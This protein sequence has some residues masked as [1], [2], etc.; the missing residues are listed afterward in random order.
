MIV[1]F[2]DFGIAG[3][4]VGQM[5]AVLAAKAPQEP[6]IDLFHEA[7][8]HDPMAA[9]YLLPA[10]ISEFPAGST[11]LAVVDPGVGGDR[12]PLIVQAGGSW[13]VGPDN[14]L[15]EL[16]IR[17]QSGAQAWEIT[18]RPE[19]LS[20]SFHGRDLFAPVA[21]MLATG[22]APPG[23]E[24]ALET[25]RRTDWP[26]ELDQ[27]IYIDHFGNAMTGRRVETV[28]DG[29]V[30]E[31]AAHCCP[32]ARTFSDQAPGQPFWYEN[33]N[34]LAEIAVNLGRAERLP[35][36]VGEAIHWLTSE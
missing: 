16:I 28:P 34:G 8:P 27:I 10:L 6:I 1:L 11:F 26:D 13:F 30:L 3:P 17:R 4:Y 29:S 12:R 2:T 31:V 14:G 19:K 9:A 7:P 18:Y 24:I 25:I 20:N 5:H 33:A 32:R 22:T 15:F 23:R 36:A 35:L 21:A